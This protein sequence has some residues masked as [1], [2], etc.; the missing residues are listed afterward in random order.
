MNKKVLIIAHGDL[1]GITS[2]ALVAERERFGIIGDD[3]AVIFTQPYEV[4]TEKVIS[5]VDMAD[6][7]YVVDI[8]INN[9]DQKMTQQFYDHM[10]DKLIHWYDHHTGWEGSDMTTQHGGKVVS[11]TSR[12]CA[13]MLSSMSDDRVQDA[14]IADTREGELS[15]RG[16]LIDQAIKADMSDDFTR[17][18]ALKVLWTGNAGSKFK[19][20]KA[21]EKYQQIAENTQILSDMYIV[22]DCP[23]SRNRARFFREDIQVPGRDYRGKVA[24]C[25]T[26]QHKHGDYDLTQLLLKGQELADFA[27]VV[28]SNSDGVNTVTIATKTGVNLLD[29]LWNIPSGAT[30]RVTIPFKLECELEKIIKALKEVAL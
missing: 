2:A 3:L 29:V 28:K 16:T 27:A 20:E 21:A 23:Y 7:V 13:A 19:L 8:A 1:D 25:D 6:K 9:R 18:E 11:M 5:A 14:V 15:P 26:R 24:V 12:A 22:D 4:M 30:F 17:M 10:G